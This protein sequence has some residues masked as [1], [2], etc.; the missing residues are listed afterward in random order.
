MSFF[1]LIIGPTCKLV[2]ASLATCALSGCLAPTA[3]VSG[4]ALEQTPIGRYILATLFHTDDAEIATGTASKIEE[5][6]KEPKSSP[7]SMLP[8]QLHWGCRVGVQHNQ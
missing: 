3:R 7:A 2:L 8:L 1:G 6:L 4:E 5:N